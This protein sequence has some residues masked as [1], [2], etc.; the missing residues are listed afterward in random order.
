MS[1][2]PYEWGG[3]IGWRV[4]RKVGSRMVCRYFGRTRKAEAEAFDAD[5]ELEARAIKA[6]AKAK[7]EAGVVDPVPW[8][9]LMQSSPVASTSVRGI[10]RIYVGRAQGTVYQ[11][12]QV[13]LE[14][15][16]RVRIPIKGDLNEA[17]AWASALTAL[18]PK[19][20]RSPKELLARFPTCRV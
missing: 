6:A 16:K 18:A 8:S 12:F 2:R 5:L 10:S 19:V 4:R 3:L 1:V 13:Y 14:P 15:G 17:Q 20:G 7:A 9:K 11:Y